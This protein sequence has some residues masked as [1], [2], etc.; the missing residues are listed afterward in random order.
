M[1]E[2]CEKS[3]RRGYFE[4]NDVVDGLR[5]SERVKILVMYSL[6]LR[7]TEEGAVT[8]IERGESEGEKLQ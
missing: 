6:V 7:K 3:A 1:Y 8:G 2:K 5:R 4:E